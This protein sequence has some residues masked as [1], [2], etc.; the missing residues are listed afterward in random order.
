MNKHMNRD[1]TK[2][3][4][5][6]QS[7]VILLHKKLKFTCYNL[8]MFSPTVC[9]HEHTLRNRHLNLKIRRSTGFPQCNAARREH[10]QEAAFGVGVWVWLFNKTRNFQWNKKF[11]FSTF[12]RMKKC[13]TIHKNTM[14]IWCRPFCLWL[15]PY[16]TYLYGS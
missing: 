4:M 14:S 15:L 8:T 1:L 11:N 9:T 10:S 13:K 6:Y 2:F 5:V 7:K 12:Y 16:K 3:K